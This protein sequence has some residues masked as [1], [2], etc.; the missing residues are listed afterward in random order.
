MAVSLLVSQ[1]GKRLKNTCLSKLA[2]LLHG[3]VAII[4]ERFGKTIDDERIRSCEPVTASAHLE[5]ARKQLQCR[6]MV[7]LALSGIFG[8]TF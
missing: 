5:Q 8:R 4:P 2:L 1:G 3:A 7:L 6:V